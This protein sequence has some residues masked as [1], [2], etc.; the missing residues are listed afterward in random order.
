MAEII[1]RDHKSSIDRPRGFAREGNIKEGVKS[2]RG[3]GDNQGG[4]RRKQTEKQQQW[5]HDSEGACGEGWFEWFQ[6][7]LCVVFIEQADR[8][9]EIMH[10]VKWI[11]KGKDLQMPSAA[12]TCQKAQPVTGLHLFK[13]KRKPPNVSASGFRNGMWRLQTHKKKVFRD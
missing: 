10:G 12:T 1:K 8:Q 13:V 5:P 2:R 9:D 4:K 6:R 7:L 3:L 11:K